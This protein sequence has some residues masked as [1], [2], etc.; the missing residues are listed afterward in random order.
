MTLD[1]TNP[2]FHFVFFSGKLPAPV[3]GFPMHQDYGLRAEPLSPIA[4][5]I[6]EGNIE[7]VEL[8]IKE[9]DPPE[10]VLGHWTAL[11]LSVVAKQVDVCRL[12]LESGVSA[13][14]SPQAPRTPL[15]LAAEMG[16]RDVAS[17]LIEFGADVERI[18]EDG[19]TA[20]SLAS[21]SAVGDI[22]SVLSAGADPDF[23]NADG[24]S[25]LCRA[26][27]WSPFNVGPLLNAGADPNIK[28][29]D[30]T[31]LTLAMDRGSSRSIGELFDFGGNPTSRSSRGVPLIYLAAKEGRIE[32]C[33]RILGEGV[34]PLSEEVM[35]EGRYPHEIAVGDTAIL[36]NQYIQ[37]LGARK[38]LE[39]ITAGHSSPKDGAFP[40]DDELFM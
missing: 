29:A 4:Q 1:R 38:E 36:I 27:L 14:G 21:G 2:G 34:D 28:T 37:A 19:H 20:L 25:C 18:S 33:R 13:N 11:H 8:W 15:M 30:G 5:N 17:L 40:Q 23:I 9:N 7:G 24:Q 39:R 32:A 6:I 12:L 22:Q 31:P 26:I 16:L 35:F 10:L 3:S